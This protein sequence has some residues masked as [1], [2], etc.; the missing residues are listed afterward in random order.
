MIITLQRFYGP[1][2][3]GTFGILR[4]PEFECFTV[5]R[6]WRGNSPNV[7]C[8]PEGEYQL[9]PSRYLRGGY[10]TYEIVKVPDRTAIKIHVGNTMLN[11]LGCIALGSALGWVESP[12]K[13][14]YRWGVVS[15]KTAFDEFME[16]M[17]G[18][19]E[20]T[21]RIVQYKPEW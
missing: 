6:P 16:R 17:R 2:D 15:S 14:G 3:M 21:I 20:A 11:V 5:E 12:L 19:E 8:I 7:S 9:I 10:D 1:G 13:S 4:L 18:V